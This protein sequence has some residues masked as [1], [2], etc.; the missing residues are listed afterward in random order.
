MQENI[1]LEMKVSDETGSKKFAQKAVAYFRVGDTILLYG[2]LGSGK[3]YLTNIFVKLLSSDRGAISPSFSIINQYEGKVFI[4][5]LDFYR[6]KNYQELFNLGLDD[7]LNMNSINFIE[8]P[9]IIENKIHWDHFRIY[10]ETDTKNNSA[11]HFK[12]KRV[13]H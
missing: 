7:I 5:H 2:D 3:T 1:L 6:I 11:R 12:L 4:N 8:W 9:Q 13:C 10:I